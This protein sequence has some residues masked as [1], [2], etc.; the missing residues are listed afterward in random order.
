ME[1]HFLDYVTD[2]LGAIVCILFYT[3]P[4]LCAIRAYVKANTETAKEK[5]LSDKKFRWSVVH[6][7]DSASAPINEFRRSRN[8]KLDITGDKIIETRRAFN[9]F[10]ENRFIRPR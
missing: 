2:I 9:E 8:P 10:P 4:V 1:V 5:L 6:H 3:T 7:Y